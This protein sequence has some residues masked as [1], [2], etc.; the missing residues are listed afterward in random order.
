MVN[1][2]FDK[3]TVLDTVVKV[4]NAAAERSP[5]PALEG[6]KLKLMGNILEFTGYNLEIGIQ[7][8]LEV[9]GNDNA[10]FVINARLFSDMLRRLPDDEI[11]LTFDDNFQ[12]TIESS[13]TQYTLPAFSSN[14]YPSLP[15]FEKNDSFTIPQPIFKSMIGQT[16]FAVSNAEDKPIL[17]GE[18]LEVKPNK[19]SLIA[20]D[21]FR[22][23]IRSENIIYEG[24]KNVIIPAKN[25]SNISKLLSDSDEDT[26]NIYL[27]D[28][29]VVFEID[30]DTNGYIVY[31]R[32][33]EGD[34]IPYQNAIPQKSSI[35]VNVNRSDL[36]NSLERA[37]PLIS[38][39]TNDPI[40][41]NFKDK[42]INVKLKSS[43]GKISDNVD[44]T[45][46]GDD[47]E[48]GFKCKYLIDPLKAVGNERIR[49]QLESNVKPAVI[50][51]E[52]SDSFKF[53][54]LPV[55]LSR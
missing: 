26:C 4:S 9:D 12:V 3:K 30:G 36:L 47:L 53:L 25:L 17:K 51:P 33:I 22:L 46:T 29:Q 8:S 28:K 24:S 39:R 52:D 32:I 16:I 13:Q 27:N 54:V 6:I 49:L 48:I 15:E 34:F 2:K 38:D 37:L 50:I 11:K 21:G 45:K 7:T 31:S 14:D 23:A 35:D 44:C 41:C 42:K 40:R 20:M 43:L 10:E 1:I 18:L 5:I 55:R 19:A